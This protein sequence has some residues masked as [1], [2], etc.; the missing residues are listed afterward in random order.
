MIFDEYHFGAW[1]E[2]AKELFEKEDEENAVEFDA[3]NTR[4]T[5]RAMP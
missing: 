3:E 5:R 4:K 2:R 1:K